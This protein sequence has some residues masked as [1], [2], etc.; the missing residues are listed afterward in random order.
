MK[1]R[2]LSTETYNQVQILTKELSKFRGFNNKST[3][4][5]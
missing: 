1:T 4:I 2:K 5:K 3:F